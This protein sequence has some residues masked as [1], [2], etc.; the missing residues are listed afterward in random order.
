MVA[1]EGRGPIRIAR[2]IAR[3]N[4]GGPA[5]QAILLTKEIG[6]ARS[7]SFLITGLV[8]EAEGDMTP[9]ARAIKVDPLVEQLLLMMFLFPV[10]F[11]ILS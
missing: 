8:G 5:I 10:W 4:I 9:Y 7:S 11:K 2:I 3:L 1:S 6:D